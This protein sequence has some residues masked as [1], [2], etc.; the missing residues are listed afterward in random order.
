[1]AT[2]PPHLPLFGAD[3]EQQSGT[4]V[5]RTADSAE[6][7]S[8]CLS[9]SPHPAAIHPR[10]PALPPGPRSD[11]SSQ[12]PSWTACHCSSLRD[13]HAQGPL[14]QPPYHLHGTPVSFCQHSPYALHSR[15][16]KSK[17][18]RNFI[19]P[20]RLGGTGRGSSGRG[21]ARCPSLG[22]SE[23]HTVAR[24]PLLPLPPLPWRPGAKAFVPG[25]EELL[26]AAGTPARFLPSASLQECSEQKRTPQ[27]V[28]EKQAGWASLEFPKT[29][30]S[31]SNAHF[32]RTK[33]VCKAG[34][35]SLQRFG[36]G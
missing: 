29:T 19:P 4:L 36:E 31:Y 30:C 26:V 11:N 2:C 17:G 10:P 32:T 12:D 20:P 13:P 8:D 3:P 28:W 27:V 33:C 1:M 23:G 34:R 21:G 35:S 7:E 6:R 22:A 15:A 25:S 24:Q 14:P 18:V 16:P 9:L 5:H